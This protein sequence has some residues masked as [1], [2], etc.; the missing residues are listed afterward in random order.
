MH[1]AVSKAVGKRAL[2][3]G[4]IHHRPGKDK[5]VFYVGVGPQRFSVVLSSTEMQGFQNV[6]CK[7]WRHGVT[8]WPQSRTPEPCQTSRGILIEIDLRTRV[9]V[10]LTGFR[11]IVVQSAFMCTDIVDSPSFLDRLPSML[12]SLSRHDRHALTNIARA[13][14][15]CLSS[16][17]ALCECP[18]RE[19]C[20]A[21]LVCCHPY[22]ARLRGLDQM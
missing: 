17:T 8:V 1:E 5:A 11:T 16:G 2:A 20:T 15:F 7:A 13:D 19:T 3:R 21:L 10:A 4:P 18:I 14:L 22:R 12:A 9:C 6:W